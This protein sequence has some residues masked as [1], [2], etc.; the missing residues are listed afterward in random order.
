MATDDEESGETRK[1]RMRESGKRKTKENRLNCIFGKGWQMMSF[2]NFLFS[3]SEAKKM[4]KREK[5]SEERKIKTNISLKFSRS[6][7]FF[8][9]FWFLHFGVF[10]SP[11]KP[12]R[13]T[14]LTNSQHFNIRFKFFFLLKFFLLYLLFLF[15]FS[16]HLVTC[17][18]LIDSTCWFCP[19]CYISKKKLP[20]AEH[21]LFIVRSATACLLTFSLVPPSFLHHCLS[22]PL[23]L[24]FHSPS[25]CFFCAFYWDLQ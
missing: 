3:S 2:F 15:F 19:S 7:S 24:P 20:S 5:N 23:S 13:L 22:H 8:Y 4:G 25:S 11:N 10:G 17:L 18:A 6:I 21:A 14:E 16:T 12:Y 1:R 9:F